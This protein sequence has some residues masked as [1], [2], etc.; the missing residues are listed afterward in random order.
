MQTLA[1][2]INL[3]PFGNALVRPAEWQQRESVALLRRCDA[4][5]AVASV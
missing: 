3:G 4:L 5:R 2:P 1:F